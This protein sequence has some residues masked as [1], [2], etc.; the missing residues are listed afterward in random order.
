MIKKLKQGYHITL[1]VALIMMLSIGVFAINTGQ[2]KKTEPTNLYYYVGGK[3]WMETSDQDGQVQRK[4]LVEEELWVGR[5]EIAEV[6]FPRLYYLN[7]EKNQLTLID[8]K[9]RIYVTTTLPIKLEN[10][11]TKKKLSEL[12]KE[13]RTGKVKKLRQTR[14]VLGRKCKGYIF[15][16]QTHKA[17]GSIEKSNTTVWATTDVPFDLKIYYQLLENLRII[18]NRDKKSRKQLKKIKGIQLLVQ[19]PQVQQGK[20]IKYISEA[21]E[22]SKKTPPYPGIDALIKAE[23]FKKV[24]RFGEE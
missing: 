6:S 3:V 4:K 24:E 8:L 7:A 19:L 10:I 1:I 15:K 20:T 14:E 21:V 13:K 18:H 5:N 12:E 16:A 23:G 9:K 22:I 2:E 17:D 11:Y